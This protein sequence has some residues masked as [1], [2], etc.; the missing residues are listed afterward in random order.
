[1][2]FGSKISEK[3]VLGGEATKNEKNISRHSSFF[4]FGGGGE[5]G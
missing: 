5:A 1:M 2:N 4:F 3:F